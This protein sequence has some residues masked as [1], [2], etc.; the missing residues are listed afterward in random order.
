M[1]QDI[2]AV[3]YCIGLSVADSLAQ[4]ELDAINPQVMAEAIA[5][6][7]QGK[8]LK[9]SADEA[10]QIIQNYI[11]EITASKFEE[12]KAEGEAF[13]AEN[14]KKAGVTTTASGLQYEV[15]E[16]GT[17]VKPS[18]SDTVKVH[19]HGTLIDGT[20]FDSS[21]SRGL[22]ATFGVHQVIKGW[23]EALQLMPVGS[24]Y[25]LYI[26][27]DLAYGAHPHPGG[28]I[29]PFMALIF[30]VELIAIEN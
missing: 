1:S 20:V 14:A 22:P 28:A 11:Q 24:K 16:E 23:T 26:P 8:E 2:N 29:K 5:D 27:Q 4:Q 9:F 7:F 10:N 18:A 25:R 19:Y 17:G 13:L 15:I 12:H 3:S 6:V 21:I 30:D